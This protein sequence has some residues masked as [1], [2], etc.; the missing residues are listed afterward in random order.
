MFPMRF[1]QTLLLP[2]LLWSGAVT[3]QEAPRPPCGAQPV[4]A[5]AAPSAKPN[6]AI[7]RDGG[8]TKNGWAFPACSNWRP[9]EFKLVVALAGSFRHQGSADE[10]LHRFGRVSALRS[11]RYWSVSDKE[12]RRL[13]DDAAALDEPAAGRRRKDFTIAEMKAKAPLYF[14]QAESRLS[15]PVVYRL[16]VLELRADRLV[17]ETEN[18]SVMRVALVPIMAPG[19]TRTVHVLERLSPGLWGYYS[20]AMSAQ[21]PGLFLRM[22]DASLINRATAFYRHFVGIPT[23]REPPPAR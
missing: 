14:V 2:L 23:D 11:I 5:Y 18:V 6:V 19:E 9:G 1:R 13:I 20:L 17:V 3:A 15:V 10:L 16:S 21:D 7:W 22:R 12:W 8:G 4:P